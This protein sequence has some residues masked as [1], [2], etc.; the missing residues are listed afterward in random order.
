MLQ[1][2]HRAPG[3]GNNAFTALFSLP[4]GGLKL[5]QLRLLHCEF[6]FLVEA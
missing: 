3:L 5:Q 1:I 4:T 2:E 6:P